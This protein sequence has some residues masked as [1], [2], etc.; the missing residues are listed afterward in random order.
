MTKSIIDNEPEKTPILEE[1]LD[2]INKPAFKY[3][4]EKIFGA[5]TNN[6]NDMIM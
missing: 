3:N 1:I 2:V 6:N 5:N 4:A